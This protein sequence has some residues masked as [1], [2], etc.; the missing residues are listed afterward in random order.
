MLSPDTASAQVDFQSR[1]RTHGTDS[2]STDTSVFV[3]LGGSVSDQGTCWGKI[4]PGTRRLLAGMAEEVTFYRLTGKAKC[5]TSKM[6]KNIFLPGLRLCFFSLPMCLPDTFS[7]VSNLHVVF[8]SMS[9]FTNQGTQMTAS[10]AP[11]PNQPETQPLYWRRTDV[12]VTCR[13][14]VTDALQNACAVCISSSRSL[15]PCGICEGSV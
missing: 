13:F 1:R 12:I 15:Y 6:E 10:P 2:L 3:L 8:L 11:P 9:T 7:L 4:S 14:R 5:F